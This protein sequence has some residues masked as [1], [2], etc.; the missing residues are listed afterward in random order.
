MHSAAWKSRLLSAHMQGSSKAAAPAGIPLEDYKQM[1]QLSDSLRGCH[2]AG[3][4]AR[5][6]YAGE[7]CSVEAKP[8]HSS[9]TVD[10]S[11]HLSDP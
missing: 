11:G 7:W 10:L 3:S 5:S 2:L 1:K 9:T 4:D 6:R 8:G